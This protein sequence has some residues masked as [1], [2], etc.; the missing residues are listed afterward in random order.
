LADSSGVVDIGGEINS[1]WSITD[2][3][4]W[5]ISDHAHW[6]ISDFD[7]YHQDNSKV[8]EKMKMHWIIW[9]TN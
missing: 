5:P 2:L 1:L 3:D 8:N 6:P 9:S 4:L 7:L